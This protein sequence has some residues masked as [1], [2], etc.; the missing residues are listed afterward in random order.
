[1]L[2]D[3][4]WEQQTKADPLSL[5]SL[6]AWL[7]R[8]PTGAQY[9]YL[10]NGRCLL[11]Q[12]FQSVGFEDPKIGSETFDHGPWSGNRIME[13]LPEVFNEISIQEPW[14]FG[15]ALKRARGLLKT[16]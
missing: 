10:D 15:A 7:K 16:A 1:M 12:Y 2:Y 3:P 11:G 4:K 13:R 6:I 9:C 8:Q 5:E 14:T